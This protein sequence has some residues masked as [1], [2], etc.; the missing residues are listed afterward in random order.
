M[1]KNL[2][3]IESPRAVKEA[4]LHNVPIDEIVIGNYIN[5]NQNNKIQEIIRIANSQN[6]K[7]SKVDK[8][9]LEQNS[10]R[11][12]HQGVI[13]KAKPFEYTNLENIIAKT[14]DKNASLIVILDHIEDEGNLGAIARSAEA[15][16]ADGLIIANKRAA[17]V[18]PTTYISSAGAIFNLPISKVANI[19]AAIEQLKQ[20]EFWIASAS[21]HSEKNIWEENLRGKLAL[22]LGSEHNGVS[23]LVLKNSDFCVKLP[24][25]GD[26]ESLN[27]ASA[28]TACMY[29]WVRQNA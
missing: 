20:N 12:S 18:T 23:E 4:L 6:I 2:E 3:N 5:V 14:K 16:G 27:V 24:I 8:N 28:A 10:V 17:S 26:T 19:N 21:E 13:A 1:N 9:V 11:G 29:E 7:V 22:V 25:C 15:F